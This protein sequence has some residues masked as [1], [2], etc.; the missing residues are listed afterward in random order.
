VIPNQIEEKSLSSLLA[1]CAEASH[2]EPDWNLLHDRLAPWLRGAIGGTLNLCR[3]QRRRELLDELAQEFWCRVLAADRRPLRDYR[4]GTDRE[5]LAYLRRIVTTVVF[6]RVR[7][8]GAFKRWLDREPAFDV[9]AAIGCRIADRRGCPELRLLARERAHSFAALCGELIG[10]A[11]RRERLAIARLAFV[12][13]RS[14]RE[15]VERV[16]G[17]WSEARV[18]SF[19]FRLRQRL[20][21]RGVRLPF[22]A[23][24]MAA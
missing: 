23:R 22:R 12:E 14:S 13:G 3:V 16:G 6:D 5:A 18:N 17:P 24:E 7:H 1:R 15:I 20:A 19:L 9:G 8:E 21:A 4:G 2:A 11:R 10:P